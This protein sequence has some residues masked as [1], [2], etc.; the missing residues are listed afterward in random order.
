MTVEAM[1]IYQALEMLESKEHSFRLLNGRIEQYDKKSNKLVASYYKL[2]EKL[3][4]S[5]KF[6]YTFRRLN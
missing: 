3:K 6:K 5:D 2:T 4:D 1:N